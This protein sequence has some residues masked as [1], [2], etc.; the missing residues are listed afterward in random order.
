MNI[1]AFI[2]GILFKMKKS[3]LVVIN[4]SKIKDGKKLW[5]HFFT[6]FMDLS[7]LPG[8]INFFLQFDSVS[9]QIQQK[10]KLKN[11]TIYNWTKKEKTKPRNKVNQRNKRPILQKL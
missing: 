10:E 5:N 7:C 3:I 4:F 6:K 2:E 9:F 1:K 11:N 8:N